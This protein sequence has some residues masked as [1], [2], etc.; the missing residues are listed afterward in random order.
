MLRGYSIVTINNPSLTSLKE[1]PLNTLY[2]FKS[3]KVHDY[4]VIKVD[5]NS[6]WVEKAIKQGDRLIGTD[7]NIFEEVDLLAL[8]NNGGSLNGY[9]VN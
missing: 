6:F 3:Y 9:Q 1:L 8:I 2:L 5:V 7:G 4:L